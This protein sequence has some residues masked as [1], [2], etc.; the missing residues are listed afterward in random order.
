MS[1]DLNNKVIF[2][3]TISQF[4]LVRALRKALYQTPATNKK[5]PGIRIFSHPFWRCI[6]DFKNNLLPSFYYVGGALLAIGLA[7]ALF[8]FASELAIWSLIVLKLIAIEDALIIVLP[9]VFSFVVGQYAL[10]TAAIFE[11]AILTTLALAVV[12]SGLSYCLDYISD[13]V[14]L[15]PLDSLLQQSFSLKKIIFTETDDKVADKEKVI[16][17]SSKVSRDIEVFL[18]PEEK[19]S[20]L[21]EQKQ[22]LFFNPNASNDD[23]NQTNVIVKKNDDE[24]T[25]SFD[26]K[27]VNRL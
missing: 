15:T 8:A 16:N 6:D 12:F 14:G 24:V 5:G 27:E 11:A 10:I 20:A 23:F 18:L 3:E 1:Q 22:H 13:L 4:S 9:F 19:V 17:V 21:K 7:T 25:E 2:P 26:G